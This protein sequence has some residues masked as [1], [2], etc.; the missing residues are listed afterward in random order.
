M[1]MC[2]FRVR[3]RARTVDA[4]SWY[5]CKSIQ[6]PNYKSHYW[7]ERK[8]EAESSANSHTCKICFI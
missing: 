7:Y 5:F 1:M 2:R 6:I 3:A 8:Q 4:I